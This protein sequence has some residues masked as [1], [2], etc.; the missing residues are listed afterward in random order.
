MEK[1]LNEAAKEYYNKLK[2]HPMN[3]ND[4]IKILVDFTL[5]QQKPI[6]ESEL[7]NKFDS[8]LRDLEFPYTNGSDTKIFDWFIE[9]IRH[10]TI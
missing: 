5:L 1:K 10:K 7:K 3:G 8:I 9:N 6:N 4:L 2:S